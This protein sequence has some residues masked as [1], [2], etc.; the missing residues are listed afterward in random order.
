MRDKKE[1]KLV[2]YNVAVFAIVLIAFSSVLY[3]VVRDGLYSDMRTHL[4]QMV[5]GVISS[6]DYEHVNSK[7][8]LPDL[9]VS[10]LP[11]SASGSLQNLRLQWFNANGELSIEKGALEVDLP[12]DKNGGF[13][14]QD[15]PRAMFY[16]K[17]VVVDKKLLGYARV[18][19]PLE[20]L[21]RSME[22]IQVG[23]VLGVLLSSFI[24]G[25]GI[26][27]LISKSMQPLYSSIDQLKQFTSDASHELRTPVTAIQSN[28]SVALKYSDGMRP[29]DH[30]KFEMICN[31]TQQMSRLVND[32]L[33][34]EQSNE[35]ASL[36]NE[37][38]EVI[39]VV[40]DVRRILSWLEDEKKIAVS[41]EIPAGLRVKASETE[42]N[43]ILQNLLDNAL[44][45]SQTGGTVR[46]TAM[47]ERSNIVIKVTDSGAGISQADLP[48]IF[49]RFWR[50]DKA[51]SRAAGGNGLGLAI[52]K[53][54]I[55]RL[56]G[57]ID[58]ES[59]INVGSTF[60]VRL[61]QASS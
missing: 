60:V 47:S 22:H 3:F 6:I 40:E 49:D 19:Q 32:L 34:L 31:A 56:N 52:V 20:D 42:L 46:I 36:R 2:L 30:E 35:T 51:R 59:K 39:A 10:E 23:L 41:V 17:V 18:G 4:T 54:I 28:A 57:Q 50:A 15:S 37:A 29:G 38:A 61:P 45:Y 26:K 5:D 55:D 44:R 12:L 25:I 14:H 53:S 43:T 9:I 24:C 8:P 16:T 33:K 21:D 13:G 11:A 58:V 7:A 27:I 48:K 1:F